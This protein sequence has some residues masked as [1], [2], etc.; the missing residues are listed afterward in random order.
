MLDFISIQDNGIAAFHSRFNRNK[1]AEKQPLI[2]A[3]N[4]VSAKQI[5]K[6][7]FIFL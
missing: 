5:V 2:I 7:D 1:V 3:C 4:C 6:D